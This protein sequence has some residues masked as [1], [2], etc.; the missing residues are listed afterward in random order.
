MVGFV[1]HP[2][3]GLLVAP[4][5]LY[6]VV[7]AVVRHVDLAADEPLGEGRVPLEDLIPLLEPVQLFGPALPKALGI[8]RGLLPD[9]GILAVG[10]FGEF[11]R[12]WIGALRQFLVA[13]LLFAH[14]SPSLSAA[15]PGSAVTAATMFLYPCAPTVK[16]VRQRMLSTGRLYRI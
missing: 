16:T 1:A 5:L 6:L 10:V 12:G 11:F 8:F 15:D 14:S 9:L 7:Q 4:T 13:L 2:D 3:Q